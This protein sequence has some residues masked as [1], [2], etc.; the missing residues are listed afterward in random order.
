[1][2][3]PKP[4]L[5]VLSLWLLACPI[6]AQAQ[7]QP[8]NQ[9]FLQTMAPARTLVNRSR[10][11]VWLTLSDRAS[12]ILLPSGWRITSRGFFH[13]ENGRR[14]GLFSHYL[15]PASGSGGLLLT[16]AYGAGDDL[17]QFV[18]ARRAQRLASDTAA[19]RNDALLF[20]AYR[21]FGGL[22]PR[23]IKRHE[24]NKRIRAVTWGGLSGMSISTRD[25]TPLPSRRDEVLN[26]EQRARYMVTVASSEKLYS[27]ADSTRGQ[28]AAVRSI[29]ASFRPQ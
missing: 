3:N 22:H 10:K 28:S 4:V 24:A 7:T 27:V 21:R 26:L 20:E 14:I 23:E 11:A 13:T 29:L 8:Q 15:R 19:G 16:I 6:T 17:S 25:G 9:S 5:T 18:D 2:K 1:M 12:Q